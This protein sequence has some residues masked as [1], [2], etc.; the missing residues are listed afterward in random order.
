MLKHLYIRNYALF[1]ETQVDFP[2]G[3][4]ILT[5]ETGAGKSMLIGALGLIIGKRADNSVIFLHED[6]CIIE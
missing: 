1:E 3:L 5:G 6:K 2:E 4:T